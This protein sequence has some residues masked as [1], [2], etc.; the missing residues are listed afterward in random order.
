MSNLAEL[1]VG[2]AGEQACPG[3][4]PVEPS[5]ETAGREMEEGERKSDMEEGEKGRL[6]KD[7]SSRREGEGGRRGRR[8]QE[9]VD[10]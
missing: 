10:G 2:T 4:S 6:Y 5:S 1:V 7:Q 8:N 9:G 3:R